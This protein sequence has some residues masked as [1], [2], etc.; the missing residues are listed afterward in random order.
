MPEEYSR[1]QTVDSRENRKSPKG[2]MENQRAKIN[3]ESTKTRRHEEGGEV[4]TESSISGDGETTRVQS[5]VKLDHP[6]WRRVDPCS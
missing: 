4:G 3:H 2:M 5:R 6:A 1:Q